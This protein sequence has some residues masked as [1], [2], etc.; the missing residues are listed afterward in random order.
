MNSKAKVQEIYRTV[1]GYEGLYEISNLGNIKSLS[2]I[3]KHNLGG[4]KLLKE[5]WL[6]PVNSCN[7]YLVMI[8]SIK[9]VANAKKEEVIQE[10]GKLRVKVNAPAVDGKANKAVLKI[11]A[12]YFKVR[13]RKI[14]IIKGEK[15]KDKLIEVVKSNT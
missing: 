3:V 7:G 11:L 8:I 2:R 9:V 4:D 10:E 15:N 14:T 5:R 1:K 12:K 6:K 13:P